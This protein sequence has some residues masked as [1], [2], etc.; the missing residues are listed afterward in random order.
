MELTDILTD[1]IDTKTCL[2]VANSTVNELTKLN[3]KLRGKCAR[4]NILIAGLV[5]F[6]FTACKMLNESDRKRKD[7][8]K[9]ARQA[10]SEL[11]AA[12]SKTTETRWS[13]HDDPEKDICCDGKASVTKKPE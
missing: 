12:N 13:L 8:E 11:E 2:E 6:G 4:K 1:L 10:K 7:A 5:W 9:R 3:K